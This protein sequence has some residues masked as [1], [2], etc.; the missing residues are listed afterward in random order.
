MD[1]PP[2]STHHRLQLRPLPTTIRRHLVTYPLLNQRVQPHDL[3]Q[4]IDL[5]V[6]VNIRHQLAHRRP[7]KPHPS[8]IDSEP[9]AP[10]RSLTLIRKEPQLLVTHLALVLHR[11]LREQLRDLLLNQLHERPI[12][13]SLHL[14]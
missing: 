6:L 14:P 9:P 10:G 12:D 2:P 11:M 3:R 5:Q 7:L 8:L 1:R 13:L 4:L